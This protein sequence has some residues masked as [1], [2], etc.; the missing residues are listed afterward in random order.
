M[1]IDTLNLD[2]TTLVDSLRGLDR[3][4]SRGI[5]FYDTRG[6][7]EHVPYAELWRRA[8]SFAAGLRERG[9]T[10]G[11]PVAL[12]LPDPQEAII[13]ILG[14]IAIGCPPAPIYP[15]VSSRAVPSFV[16]FLGYV[17]KRAEAARVVVGSQ[18]YPFVGTIP[19][20]VDTVTGVDRFG[21]VMASSPT[22]PEAPGADDC[23]FLQF[24]SGST[25]A[26]KGVVVTHRNLV[27]NLWMIRT[28]SRMDS[29]SVV[30]SWLPVYHDM[31]L[32][33]T[34]LNAICGHL[35]LAVLSPMTFLRRPDIWLKSITDH[36]ATHTA[37]PNF[38]YGLCT[39]RVKTPADHD[40]SS[41]RVFICGAEPIMPET[42]EQFAGHFEPAGLSRSAIVP[43][44]GL[45]EATLAV[46]F[47]PYGTGMV[48]DTVDATT[49]A[50]DR[51][52]RKAGSGGTPL[53]VPS[54]GVAL[55]AVDIR[56]AADDGNALPDRSVGEVQLRGPSITP[57]YIN[58]PE[59]TQ[60]ART[61]DGWLR[62]G[63]LGYVTGGHL[64]ACG[65]TKDL[66]ILRG[67]NLHSH[68]VEA[69]ASRVA[70]V[71]TGNVVAFG[72]AH[73]RGGEKLV[74]VAE[75]RVPESADKIE[76]E[77]RGE[78]HEALGVT[79]SEIVV[80][81]PGTLPK[82]SSGK[83]RRADTKRDWET[84]NLAPPSNNSLST[85]GIMIKSGVSHAMNRLRR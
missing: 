68:D 39:R 20:T 22:T 34:V 53:R 58:D 36:K 31:G 13:A 42:L 85:L 59:A 84:G 64:Y 78:V 45:A 56:I 51:T 69:A 38:A 15:P 19:R 11:Q 47:T 16:D 79:P 14:S 73:G 80:V 26:P 44:Y 48:V 32:I 27:A 49:L 17:C 21:A 83:L 8:L 29:E 35:D 57:R 23:A 63:D 65:R 24:T 37:A 41:M 46:T 2:S 18:V 74:I 43:A 40:L 33:G 75:S 28:A 76:R 61:A 55:P 77:I 52:A 82:T 25:A 50:A 71:R 6:R 5:T 10:P 30:C 1:P 81:P 60:Q 7:S 9:L 3:V 4:A 70:E 12:V 62:T 67:R 72:S 66:I 54:C